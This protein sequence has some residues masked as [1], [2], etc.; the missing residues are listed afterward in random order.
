[1]HH[2]A[3]PQQQR[4]TKDQ[5]LDLGHAIAENDRLGHVEMAAP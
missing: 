4:G 3:I 1:L 2:Q 5:E